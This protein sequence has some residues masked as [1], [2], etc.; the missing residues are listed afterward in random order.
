MIYKKSIRFIF[1]YATISNLCFAVSAA[2]DTLTLIQPDGSE[3]LGFCRGDEWQAWHET[4]D[5]WSIIKNEENFWV[6]AIGVNGQRL[7]SSQAIVGLDDLPYFNS[8]GALLQKHLRPDRMIN[9]VSRK[10]I[11]VCILNSSSAVI[12]KEGFILSKLI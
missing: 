10:S 8:S 12:N 4:L 11:V 6:Y 2:P 5:G 1:W 7:E 3:F 9:F